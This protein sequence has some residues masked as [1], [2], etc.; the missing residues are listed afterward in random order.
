MIPLQIV[1]YRLKESVNFSVALVGKKTIT[2]VFKSLFNM[3]HYYLKPV[4]E[5]LNSHNN[6]CKL[7]F[8]INW[9]KDFSFI[10]NF[11]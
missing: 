5:V 10:T 4:A 11:L 3:Y 7:A 6:V 1:R 2:M 8:K 9:A